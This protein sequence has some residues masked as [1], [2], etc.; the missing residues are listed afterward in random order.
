M[1]DERNRKTETKIEKYL[2]GK[3]T[4]STKKYEIDNKRIFLRVAELYAIPIHRCNYDYL[5][6]LLIYPLD[7]TYHIWFVIIYRTSI[8]I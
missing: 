4:E 8:T 2:R 6:N 1:T 5:A 3:Q 7:S